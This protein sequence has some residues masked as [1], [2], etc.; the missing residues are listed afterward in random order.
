MINRENCLL[1]GMDDL[2]PLATFHNFPI[3]MGVTSQTS[4]LDEFEDMKWVVSRTS[5]LI[6]LASLIEL[7][8]LY[9]EQTTTLAIGN[10][11]KEHHQK[12]AEF[13]GEFSPDSVL[14]IGGAHGLLNVEFEKLRTHIP[15][16]IVEPNPHPVPECRAEYIDDFIEN[17]TDLI[18][19]EM[20]VVHS[21]TLEHIYDPLS[22]LSSIARQMKHGQRMIISVPNLEEWFKRGHSNALNF[23]H[24]YL[25]TMEVLECMARSAG[26]FIEKMNKFRETHSIFLSMVLAEQP[27]PTE[28]GAFP[29]NRG[30]VEIF[31]RRIRDKVEF[32]DLANHEMQ[33]NVGTN[34]VFG[35]HIFT[36]QL[37]NLGLKGELL[38]SILDND[39]N[40][41][42]QRLYG[43]QLFVDSPSLISKLSSPLVILDAGEYTKEISTQL[44]ALNSDVRVCGFNQELD[45]L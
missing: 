27:L 3:F 19:P 30:S 9:P 21:H 31:N 15:W 12:F 23:E 24:S 7:E 18:T 20:T 4:D 28:Q 14:E 10:V 13:I 40:K 45:L 25:L 37:L 26:F 34:F 16:L 6:Q 35:A 32:I 29:I 5:G 33:N 43:T 1:T 17:Q 41:Q 42:N 2:E 8:R 36:Q 39:P 38:H 11:W 44:K 22:F